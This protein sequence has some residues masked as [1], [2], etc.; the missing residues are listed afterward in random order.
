[1]RAFLP[2]KVVSQLL[3][4]LQTVTSQTFSAAI[5]VAG[6]ASLRAVLRVFA[7]RND[8]EILSPNGGSL[9]EAWESTDLLNKLFWLTDQGLHDLQML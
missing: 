2:E 9:S 3:S 4:L 5:G 6:K 8:T 7:I 1:M